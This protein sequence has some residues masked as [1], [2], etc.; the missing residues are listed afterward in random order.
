MLANIILLATVGIVTLYVILVGYVV[1]SDEKEKA[2]EEK[3][4]ASR[5]IIL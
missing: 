5:I 2:E 4:K 3:K 1:L